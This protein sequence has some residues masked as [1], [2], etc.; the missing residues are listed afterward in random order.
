VAE[1]MEE[2][3]NGATSMVSHT[4]NLF[5]WTVMEPKAVRPDQWAAWHDVYIADKHDLGLRDW[6]MATHPGPLAQV[7]ARMLEAA[8]KGYWEPA[9]EM[10]GS[11]I[12][13]YRAATPDHD[14][15]LSTPGLE[16][17][18]AS[19]ADVRRVG[20]ARASEVQLPPPQAGACPI[21]EQAD[22]PGS[23]PATE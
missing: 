17:F 1:L 2:G 8:R 13:A 20:D 3:F 9:E 10:K 16:A 4:D 12:E 23:E 6:F 14:F 21:V 5:G 15:Q 22:E 11:W 18:I 19:G 7:A